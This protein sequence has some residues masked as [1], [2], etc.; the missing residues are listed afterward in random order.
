[1]IWIGELFRK[2]A[3]TESSKCFCRINKIKEID[4]YKSKCIKKMKVVSV[5]HSYHQKQSPV[6]GLRLKSAFSDFFGCPK[7]PIFGPKMLEDTWGHIKHLI[8]VKIQVKNSHKTHRITIYSPVHSSINQF[9]SSL[10]LFTPKNHWHQQ[11][12]T[13]KPLTST[14]KKIVRC[15]SQQNTGLCF[16]GRIWLREEKKSGTFCRQINRTSELCYVR[17][18]VLCQ[19]NSYVRGSYN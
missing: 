6:A 14:K 15:V 10:F 4:F 2:T 9:V 5:K 1:M 7:W 16:A 13:K 11:R 18:F 17:N 8:K 12:K 3:T 19:T